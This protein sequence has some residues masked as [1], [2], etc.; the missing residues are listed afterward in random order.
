[1]RSFEKNGSRIAYLDE[2]GGGTPEN[3]SVLLLL[4]AFPLTSAMF[5]HQVEEL[6]RGPGALRVV[7]LDHRGFGGSSLPPGQP[8]TSMEALAADAVALLDHLRIE[9]AVVGGV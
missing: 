4:H 3:F 5:R 8:V 1:M 7:A 6:T 2:G 9:R